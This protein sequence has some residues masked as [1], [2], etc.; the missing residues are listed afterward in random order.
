M[1]FMSE[2]MTML[3]DSQPISYQTK[4]AYEAG[5]VEDVAY[6]NKSDVNGYKQE[7]TFQTMFPP[8]CIKNHW[9]PETLSKY[10]LPNGDRIPLPVDPRP[11]VRNCTS[12]WTSSP[13]DVND[14]SDS[15]KRGSV[16]LAMQ[17]GG[18]AGKGVPYEIYVKNIETENDI[19]LNHPQDHCDGNKWEPESG[20]DI[21]NNRA[22]PPHRPTSS[23][24][25]LSRPIA[26]I[27]PKGGGNKCRVAVDEKSWNRSA[28]VFN[29]VTREDRV[30]GGTVRASEAPLS[31]NGLVLARVSNQPRVWPSMSVVFFVGSGDGGADL[32]NLA[33]GLKNNGWEITIFSK[34]KTSL[35]QGIS[36]HDLGEYVPNDIYSCVVMWEGAELLENYQY[37]PNAKAL[38]YVLNDDD[39]VPDCSMVIKS[40]VDKIIVKSAYQRSLYNCLP[41]SK[42]EVINNGLPVTLFTNFENRNLP[43]ERFRVFVSEYSLGLVAFAKDAWLRITSTYPGAEMHVWETSGD[44]KIKVSAALIGIAK[45]RGIVMHGRGS[46]DELVRERFR[47]SVHLYLE[48]YDQV[49][50]DS[51]RMSAL[52]GCIP[53]MPKRAVNTEL[54]GVNVSGAVENPDTLVE[55]A[56]AISAVFKDGVYSSGLRRRLQMDQSLRGWNATA[57]RWLTIIKGIKATKEQHS[58]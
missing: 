24:T 31:N 11:L 21:Y 48:D 25:E 20:S 54:G 42:F 47:S 27:I 37:R 5:L 44:Q 35:Q 4:S 16:G 36:Y 51:L 30:P 9:D 49:S 52:A 34:V 14:K 41:W 12:Y 15:A 22:G 46:L 13:V 19:Y 10:V 39:K 29:N 38:L 8:V 26:T 40:S 57:E 53:I 18:S 17:P 55:Y 3:L 28:R 7:R 50:C 58:L 1:A 56:K 43:R 6:M 2:S 32:A 33:A 23:F 45:G